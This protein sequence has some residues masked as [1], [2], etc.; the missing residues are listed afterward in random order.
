MGDPQMLINRRI[1]NHGGR[2]TNKYRTN[3][4]IYPV[5][6]RVRLQDAKTKIFDTN[7]TVLE[8]RATD[9][10]QIVSYIIR[11]DRGRLTTRHRKYLMQ[12]EPENDPKIQN[13]FTNLDVTAAAPDILSVAL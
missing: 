11:T 9:S 5:G 12:L 8:P 1:E 10:G 4:V 7:G 3:K 2:I 6:S 13:N